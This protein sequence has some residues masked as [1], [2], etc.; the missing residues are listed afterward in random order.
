MGLLAESDVDDGFGTCEPLADGHAYLPAFEDD[1]LCVESDGVN[2]FALREVKGALVV[3]ALR[4]DGEPVEAEHFFRPHHRIQ[5]AETGV[6][7]VDGAVGNTGL[8]QVVLRPRGFVVLLTRVVATD[9]DA[10][11]LAR[12]VEGYAGIDAVG[13]ERVGVAVATDRTGA[14]QYAHAIGRNGGYVVVYLAFS[15]FEHRPVA[16]DHDQDDGSGDG[17]QYVKGLFHRLGW[18]ML[19]G[20]KVVIFFDIRK[21]IV[22]CVRCKVYFV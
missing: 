11:Y 1:F 2:T 8:N 12:F 17:G 15:R 21:F 9:Q 3:E 16:A 19:S 18:I 13:V 6:V 10:L 5:S 4:D 7:E 20:A 14:E 22:D